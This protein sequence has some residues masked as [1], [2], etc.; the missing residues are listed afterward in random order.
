MASRRALRACALASLLALC[1]AAPCIITDKTVV[2]VYGD[3]AG[4]VGVHSAF[5]TRSYFDWWAESAAALRGGGVAFFDHAAQLNDC[6]PLASFPNLL[7]WVQPGGATDEQCAALGP[8][9]RDNILDFAASDHGHVWATCAGFYFAAGSYWWYGGFEGKA[10]APHWFPTVEGPITAIASYPDYAPTTL[11]NGLTVVYY[12]GPALGLNL[13]TSALPSGTTVLAYYDAPGV[14]KDVPAI[15]RYKGP[16]VDALFS[17]PHPEAMFNDGLVCEPPL[18]PGCI[19]E[20]QQLANWHF[21]AEELND[22]M[23]TAFEVPA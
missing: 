13:T 8:A 10:W 23:G 11:T 9:G 19:T 3:S 22:L 5:W 1:C 2:A 17:S 16:F 4:G 6:P 15:L 12:G 20:Q 21:L 14:P 18:P 7:L